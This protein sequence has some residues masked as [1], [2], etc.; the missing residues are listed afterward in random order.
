MDSPLDLPHMQVSAAEG[1]RTA[2]QQHA[3]PAAD[4][5]AC[6]LPLA[7]TNVRLKDNSEEV[8][9]DATPQ[10]HMRVQLLSLAAVLECSCQPGLTCGLCS[11]CR[12]QAAHV[13]TMTNPSQQSAHMR[14]QL[15]VS[16]RLLRVVVTA[17]A[18]QWYVSLCRAVLCPAAGV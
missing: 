11:S 13:S 10:S 18:M 7:I 6:L 5:A 14:Q 16:W 15:V 3:L 12:K 17:R 8:Q 4:A 2:V 1:L 9:C